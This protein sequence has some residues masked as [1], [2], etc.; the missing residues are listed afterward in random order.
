MRY[1]LRWA[2]RGKLRFLSHH[3][4]ALI[5]ERAARRGGVPIAYSKGFTPHPKI[6]FGSGLPVGFGSEVELLDIGLGEPLA[7]EEVIS[8]FNV[9]LPEGLEVL[10]AVPLEA[11]AISLGALIMAGDYEIT[12]LAPW[13]KPGVRRF[14]DLATYEISKPYKGGTR[15]D[16]L[17]AGVL[18]AGFN[19]EVLAMRC[20][21][22]PRS[23]RPSDVLSAI[24]AL[25]GEPEPA[26]R[27]QR[28]ALLTRTS[29]GLVP[30][31]EHHQG[32]KVAS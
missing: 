21:I 14:M 22:K 30:L 19:D 2:K 4:E 31:D 16:D 1:R 26:A 17:R 7:A 15:V 28:V 11:G 8:R 18:G 32:S 3:D 25:M 5:F 9:G 13:L 20:A 23:I 6:A 10:S 24:A 29:G 27:F 12:C